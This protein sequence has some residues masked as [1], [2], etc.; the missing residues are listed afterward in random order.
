MSVALIN[1]VMAFGYQAHLAFSERP[2]T[3]EEKSRALQ[4]AK[5][6]LRSRYSILSSPNN[7]LK[8]QVVQPLHHKYCSVL[9]IQTIL[10]MVG[11]IHP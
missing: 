7:L 9:T 10:A 6:P 11:F 3:S 4:Y 1:A 2:A 5:I 8:F